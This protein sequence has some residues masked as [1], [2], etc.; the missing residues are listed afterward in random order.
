MIGE[1]IAGIGKME[2]KTAKAHI[3]HKMELKNGVF[4]QMEK[5]SVGFDDRE[6]I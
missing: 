2:S 3:D 4:G 5:K 1:N 6:A